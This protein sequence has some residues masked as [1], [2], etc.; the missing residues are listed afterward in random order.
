MTGMGGATSVWGFHVTRP[1]I[2]SYI[3]IP[4][5][6]PLSVSETIEINDPNLTG[7]VHFVANSSVN[8][9]EQVVLDTMI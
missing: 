7:T 2:T 1:Y 9:H 8:G 3:V 5:N 4:A 6:V